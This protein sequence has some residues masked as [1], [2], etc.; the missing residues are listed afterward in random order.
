MSNLETLSVAQ[1]YQAFHHLFPLNTQAQ[2]DQ[3]IPLQQ[4]IIKTDD[5]PSQEVH[6]THPERDSTHSQP[7][8]IAVFSP[9]AGANTIQYLCPTEQLLLWLKTL[10]QTIQF[11]LIHAT[12]IQW[13]GVG[14][15]ITGE[16]GSG[17][18]RLAE[19][20]IRHHQAKLVCDD[21]PY[22]AHFNNG[23]ITALCPPT[24]AGKLHCR[25]RGFISLANNQHLAST[26]CDIQARL[27]EQN[28]N[29][30][31]FTLN[32]ECLLDGNNTQQHTQQ[33]Q[34]AITQYRR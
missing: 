28:N 20:L 9:N 25:D 26:Q 14:L 16:P 10:Q 18:S 2:L 1:F 33:L 13:Q 7:R 12:I 24:I 11:Q 3:N 17:K 22:L 34:Q 5:L 29:T 19:H 21:S 4:L 31:H 23:S 27:T 32:K 8:T 30:P 6:L 15:C